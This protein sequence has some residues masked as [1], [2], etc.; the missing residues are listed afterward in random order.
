MPMGVGCIMLIVLL[1][2]ISDEMSAADTLLGLAGVVIYG[3]L[4]T[5]LFMGLIIGRT[6]TRLRRIE[7]GTFLAT[8]PVSDRAI[9]YSMLKVGWAST[10]LTWALGTL[11]VLFGSACLICVGKGDIVTRF[12]SQLTFKDFI[13]F[14]PFLFLLIAW[15]LLGIGISLTLTGR[16][17]I[18]ASFF[19]SLL[20][21]FISSTLF[22]TMTRNEPHMKE[23]VLMVMGWA[24]GLTCGVGT[25][26]AYGVAWR[27][28]LIK[29]RTVIIAGGFYLIAALYLI[30]NE[31]REFNAL[32]NLHSWIYSVKCLFLLSVLAL[33]LAP[34]ATAPLALSWNRHR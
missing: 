32:L 5:T 16:Q 8:K 29:G 31:G 28:G 9:A 27:R 22:T 17:K 21:L 19:L 2:I 13:S 25:V 24:I 30:S 1:G 7:I 18:I 6:N 14:Y 33:P 20:I 10:L 15:T 11:I 34:L 4:G 23:I 3:P 12:L 26:W